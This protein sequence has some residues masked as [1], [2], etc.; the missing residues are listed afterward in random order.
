MNDSLIGTLLIYTN[1]DRSGKRRLP[2]GEP[3]R[4]SGILGDSIMAQV[5]KDIRHA[6]RPDWPK[7]DLRDANYGETRDPSVPAVLLELL[8]HQNYA[9]MRYALDPAF[10]RMVARAVYKGIGRFMASRHNTSFIPQP[11]SPTALHSHLTSDSLIVT[12]QAQ[13]DSLEPQADASY[14]VVYRRKNGGAWDN[15]TCVSDCRI[16]WPLQAG[17][18]YDIC[19]AG[20]NAGGI[21]L[22]SDIVSSY[23]STN[24][25]IP[26]L[27][28]DAFDEVRGPK[29][30]AFDSLTGG[31]VPGSRPIPDG[32]EMAY[33]GEQ[34][35]YNRRD[36]WHSDD[37]CG[38]GM[39][40]MNRQGQLLVGNTHDY[41]VQHGRAL[42]QLNRSFVSCTSNA[43][44]EADSAYTLIDVILG[45]SSVST[46]KKINIWA[47]SLNWTQGDKHVL[48]SGAY[49]G[50]LSHAC[51]SGKLKMCDTTYTFQQELNTER[52]SAEDV[53]AVSKLA[54]TDKVIA[55]YSDTGL[56]AAIHGTNYTIFG[57]PLETLDNFDVVYK[58]IIN[59]NE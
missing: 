20:G 2:S 12:W 58:H 24:N 6:Y 38:F 21:S 3:R 4:V 33:I 50:T 47:D 57:L 35:N 32:Y 13:R 49:V 18:R 51:A 55:R 59:S 53:S 10:R 22:R 45:K 36:P 41:T 52:L 23:R 28:V 40:N 7:R 43:L 11:L 27:V 56:P 9:D 5:V 15:G 37:D 42:Q 46:V 29:M 14:F 39:C 16:A 48:M 1:K 34:I 54:P 17:V 26:I 8:S 19:V 44:T 25:D 30:M 31:I